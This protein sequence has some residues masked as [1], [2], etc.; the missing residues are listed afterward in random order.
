MGAGA[1]YNIKGTIDYDSIK[2]NSFEVNEPFI[3]T[4]K[5]GGGRTMDYQ[6]IPIKCDIDCLA[7]DV[8]SESYYNGGTLYG[9][10]PIKITEMSLIS[11]YDDIEDISEIDESVIMD[12]LYDLKFDAKI[13]GGWIHSTF[14][15]DISCGIYDLDVWESSDFGIDE[16]VMYITN[17]DAIEVLD[18]YA[19]GDNYEERY[20][21][22]DIDNNIIS[23]DFYGDELQY[24]IDYAEENNGYQVESEKIWYSYEISDAGEIDIWDE[25][26]DY[27]NVSIEWTNPNYI[28]DDF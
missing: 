19:T 5:L 27:D 13:G 28:D 12:A 14:A 4:E 20:S 17:K 24:A 11:N 22:V 26:V 10:T 7:E 21:V 18:K 16:I 1:G 2:I 25:D 23:D 6:I 9:F 3:L 15:G 8:A